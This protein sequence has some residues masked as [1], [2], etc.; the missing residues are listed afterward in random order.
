M[1]RVKELLL[2]LCLLAACIG[3]FFW[4]IR[5]PE[6]PPVPVETV[7]EQL[8]TLPT[9][10]A[11]VETAPAEV[12]VLYESPVDFAAL[13]EQNPEIVAWLDIPDTIISYPVLRSGTDNGYYLNRN[14]DGLPDVNGSLFV[15]DYNSPELTDPVTIIYGHRMLSGA[16]FGTLQSTYETYESFDDHRF[17]RLFLPDREEWYSVVAAVPYNNNHI[18]YNYD[19]TL[20]W[21]HYSFFDRVYSVRAMSAQ[22][23]RNAYPEFGSKCLIL[24]TCLAGNRNNRYLVIG[25]EIS[26]K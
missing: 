23:D 14:V 17:I 13:W 2:F 3:L 4:R 24:S 20:E 21:D 16:F 7:R 11:P 25:K 15:E 5:E 18:L 9:E 1:K 6:K 12:D 26:Q 10:T 19:F 22:I 8:A